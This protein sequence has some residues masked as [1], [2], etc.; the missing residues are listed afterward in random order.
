MVRQPPAVGAAGVTPLWTGP[1]RRREFAQQL[2]ASTAKLDASAPTTQPG[3]TNAIT[4]PARA[5]PTTTAACENV[6][7]SRLHHHPA[8]RADPGPGTGS[9]VIHAAESAGA[10]TRSASVPATET[11]TEH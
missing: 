4:A 10:A 2:T 9:N 6:D 7:S 3:P 5:G 8:D 11:T 1:T